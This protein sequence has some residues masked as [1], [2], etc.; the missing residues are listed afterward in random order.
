[1]R[2]VRGALIPGDQRVVCGLLDSQAGKRASCVPMRNLIAALSLFSLVAALPAAAHD[3]PTSST[4]V[5]WTA[6][7]CTEPVLF[8]EVDADNVRAHIPKDYPGTE[9]DFMQK[10]VTYPGTDGALKATVVFTLNQCRDSEVTRVVNGVAQPSHTGTNVSEILVAVMWD[11]PS[12]NAFEFYALQ[13]FISD[14]MLAGAVRALGLPAQSTP[15]LVHDFA[16]NP[17]VP[18]PGAVVPFHIAIPGAFEFNGTVV[19]PQAFDSGGLATHHFHG[20]RGAVWVEHDTPVG[21][22][23]VVEATITVTGQKGAWLA[24]LLGASTVPAGGLYLEKQ[25]GHAHTAYLVD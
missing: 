17:D 20:A 11:G 21:A 14:P 15:N 16:A 12:H 6:G 19:R 10:L 23:S 3:T 8:V 7:P 13:T 4:Q 18:Q 24:Q 1:M 22:M 9:A 5:V 25:V 2:G